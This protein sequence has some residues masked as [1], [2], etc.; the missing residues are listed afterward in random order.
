M[1]DEGVRLDVS[2][3]INILLPQLKHVQGNLCGLLEFRLIRA[4]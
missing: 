4:L 3:V 1:G 2:V